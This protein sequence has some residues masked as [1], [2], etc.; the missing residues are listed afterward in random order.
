MDSP[1]GPHHEKRQASS[2]PVGGSAPFPGSKANRNVLKPVVALI[3][4]IELRKLTA[5]D[6]R[7]A[8][9]ELAS[10]RSSRTVIVAHTR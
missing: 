6:V 1:W 8:L 4:D 3:G 7:H 10:S 2:R 5:H 9:T